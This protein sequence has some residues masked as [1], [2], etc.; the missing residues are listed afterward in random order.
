MG[1]QMHGC[2]EKR[3]ESAC[4]TFELISHG[5]SLFSFIGGNWISIYWQQ[6]LHIYWQHNWTFIFEWPAT[7]MR[8]WSFLVTDK[9]LHKLS[10]RRPWKYENTM[11]MDIIRTQSSQILTWKYLVTSRLFRTLFLFSPEGPSG[12]LNPFHVVNT[13]TISAS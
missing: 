13:P 7:N 12:C 4:L 8:E 9:L 11:K 1:A 6:S 10:I 5:V 2:T 3:K